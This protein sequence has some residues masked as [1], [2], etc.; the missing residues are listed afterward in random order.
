MNEKPPSRRFS[1]FWIERLVPVLLI[2]LLLGLLAVIL[3][4]ALSFL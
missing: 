1:A 4:T 2:L 3:I